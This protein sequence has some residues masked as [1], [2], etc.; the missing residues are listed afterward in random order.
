MKANSAWNSIR[1][2]SRLENRAGT[3]GIVTLLIPPNAIHATSRSAPTCALSPGEPAV[4]FHHWELA[5][6]D[7]DDPEEII[8]YRT[9]PGKC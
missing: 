1:F 5:A 3:L 2:E 6:F 4:P 9:T 7:R 8:G